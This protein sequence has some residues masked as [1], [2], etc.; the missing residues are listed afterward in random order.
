[1]LKFLV[2]LKN[3]N[4]KCIVCFSNSLVL[5][6]LFLSIN[7]QGSKVLGTKQKKTFAF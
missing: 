1:M 7:S 3:L 2:N 5:Y 6:F 4:Q